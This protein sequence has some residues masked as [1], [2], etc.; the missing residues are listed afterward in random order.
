MQYP[1]IMIP[2]K[3][4]GSIFHTYI[5]ILRPFL[6]LGCA[7]WILMSN[8]KCPMQLSKALHKQVCLLKLLQQGFHLFQGAPMHFVG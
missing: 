1:S 8:A 7:Y 3:F 6:W 2:K 4:M 5:Y